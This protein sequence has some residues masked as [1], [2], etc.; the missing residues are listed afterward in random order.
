M[1]SQVQSNTGSFQSVGPRN[2]HFSQTATQG[3]AY[4]NEMPQLRFI[5]QRTDPNPMVVQVSPQNQIFRSVDLRQM[6]SEQGMLSIGVQGGTTS[7]ITDRYA[8]AE[9]STANTAVRQPTGAD[10]LRQ[11]MSS[12][13]MQIRP[14]GAMSA[15]VVNPKNEYVA[16]TATI[17]CAPAAASNETSADTDVLKQV[18]TVFNNMPLWTLPRIATAKVE[19]GI[20][21]N[22]LT[23]QSIVHSARDNLT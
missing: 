16:K 14:S 21:T 13:Y 5:D 2:A 20:T 4:D 23:L 6:P 12:N 18:S 9:S 22:P 10:Q 7:Q 1:Q 8:V 17:A 15:I 19:Q 3:G 11:L